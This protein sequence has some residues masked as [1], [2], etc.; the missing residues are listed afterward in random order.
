MAPKPLRIGVL[1]VHCVQ[2][3]DLA[4]LDLL[5]MASPEWLEDISMPQH[6]VDLGRPCEIHYITREGPNTMAPATSQLSI[7]VTDSLQDSAV[8]PGALDILFVPGPAPRAMPPAE[9]YLE[10]TRQHNTAGTTIIT[11]CT[12][13]LVAAHAGITKGR[14]ATAPRFLISYMKKTFPETKRWDENMRVTRDGN[15]W[16]CGGVTNGHDLMA[17][18]LRENYPAAVVN[19][20]LGAADVT[21]RALEY[22][23]SATRDSAF[24]MWQIVRAIPSS[25]LRMLTAR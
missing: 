10:F 12:G 20:V 18:Y 11:I 17:E 25:I 21:P 19:T 9:E 15:L 4:A 3:L 23:T 5:F 14:V 6:L 8:A 22:D 7:Q 24:F 16:M 1:L 13:S 2:L